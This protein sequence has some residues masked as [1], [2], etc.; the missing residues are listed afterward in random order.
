[1]LAAVTEDFQDQAG[2]GQE[3]QAESTN[4][5][6]DQIQNRKQNQVIVRAFKQHVALF[7]PGQ[8]SHG[9]NVATLYL[10]RWTEA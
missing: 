2:L 6:V 9:S 8:C 7:S 5:S 1:M 4:S 3:G 10:P